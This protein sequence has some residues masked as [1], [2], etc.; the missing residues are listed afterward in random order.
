MTEEFKNI[1]TVGS[2]FIAFISVAFTFYNSKKT[3]YINTITTSRIKYM[4]SLRQHISDYCGLA[5]HITL[6]E[7]D[8]TQRVKLIEEFDRLRF[9]IKLY[10]NRKNNFDL[11]IIEKLDAINAYT[12]PIKIIDLERELTLLINLTQDVLS[13]EWNGIK[14]EV[15]F[16]IRTTKNHNKFVSSHFENYG[17]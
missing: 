1:L 5:L 17:K 16:K 6:T 4:D 9:L 15:S 14:R 7:L 3:I 11:K 13:L 2:V 8:D 12:V 10:L